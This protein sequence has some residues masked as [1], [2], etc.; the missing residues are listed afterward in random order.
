MPKGQRAVMDIPEGAKFET[1]EGAKFVAVKDAAR[2][3]GIHP[4]VLEMGQRLIKSIGGAGAAFT[5]GTPDMVKRADDIAS[6]FKLGL[7]KVAKALEPNKKIKV[8]VH[9]E[10]NRLV[11]W[12]AA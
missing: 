8:K 10:A 2:L 12:Y 9:Q 11:F 6:T 7:R 3:G 4:V 1:L 5:L